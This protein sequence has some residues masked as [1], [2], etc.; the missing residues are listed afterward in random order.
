MAIRVFIFSANT[1]KQN[2]KKH[3]NRQSKFKICIT[4]L[5]VFFVFFKLRSD[6]KNKLLLINKSL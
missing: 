4:Q 6:D 3:K 2:Y 5:T 1:K